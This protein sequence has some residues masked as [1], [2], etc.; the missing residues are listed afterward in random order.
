MISAIAPYIRL[1]KPKTILSQSNQF[2]SAHSIPTQ[3][4]NRKSTIKSINPSSIRPKSIISLSDILKEE[5]KNRLSINSFLPIKFKSGHEN[6]MIEPGRIRWRSPIYK[7]NHR[8]LLCKQ[9]FHWRLLK[10]I[11]K[12]NQT[13]TQTQTQD[14][15]KDRMMNQMVNY[16]KGE[17][18]QTEFDS[19][20]SDPIPKLIELF[21]GLNRL[22]L[23]EKRYL[24]L[25]ESDTLPIKPRSQG[26][27]MIGA[28]EK[29]RSI[30]PKYSKPQFLPNFGVYGTRRKVFKGKKRE[31]ERDEKVEE[32]RK[33][34]DGMELKI[35][36]YRK[37]W[38]LNKEKSKPS[39]PF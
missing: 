12:P 26:M 31:R 32:V 10:H 5:E 8:T 9:A 4:S 14:P 35:A 20:R 15:M 17:I 3:R 30:L 33:R 7:S 23:R 22:S 13:Q 19:I 38:R 34:M 21:G 6:G 16:Y 28:E 27:M 2:I 39:L 24:G 1:T 36:Q 37:E 11:I 29:K 25:I 18:N